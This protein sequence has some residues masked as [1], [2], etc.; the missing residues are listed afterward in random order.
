[1]DWRCSVPERK[2]AV[3]QRWRR[4]RDDR[5]VEITHLQAF[6]GVKHFDVY[7]RDDEG[8]KGSI[9]ELTFRHRYY[10]VPKTADDD[11]VGWHET[12]IADPRLIPGAAVKVTWSTGTCVQ[13][14]LVELLDTDRV[15]L[16][17][18][19]IGAATVF[20]RGAKLEVWVG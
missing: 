3:G 12:D 6:S 14:P 2:L 13:G 18:E 9:W 8:R 4:L 7:W 15:R 10:F 20:V 16:M 5:E 1:M 11:K 17:A 19:H